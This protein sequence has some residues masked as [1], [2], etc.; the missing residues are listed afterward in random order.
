MKDWW[1]GADR[2]EHNYYAENSLSQ[3]HCVSQKI[4]WA[5]LGWKMCFRG[6][7]PT[8]DYIYLV[9]SYLTEHPRALSLERPIAESC[10][11]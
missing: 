10:F 7:R 3:R 1:N 2:G 6:E 4:T 9:I 5:D 8:T 11:L